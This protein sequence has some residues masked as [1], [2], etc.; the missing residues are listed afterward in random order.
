MNFEFGKIK[1]KMEEY[2]ER[3]YGYSMGVN[4]EG[5]IKLYSL[6]GKGFESKLGIVNTQK[7]ISH[8]PIKIKVW[9]LENGNKYHY[10]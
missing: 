10:Y 4:G 3:L 6:N 1:V 5:R 7:E 9:E 8:G 2:G